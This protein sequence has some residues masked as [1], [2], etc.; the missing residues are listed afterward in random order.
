MSKTMEEICQ[1]MM[2]AAGQQAPAAASVQRAASSH[3]LATGAAV[4]AAAGLL[5]GRGLL[6]AVFANPLVMLTTGVAAG[7]LVHKYQREIIATAIR[8]TDM[9]KDFALEQKE[10]LSDL[11][12]EAKETEES[13]TVGEIQEE[14]PREEG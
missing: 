5:A 12:E 1:E 13:R 7:Y 10:K 11:I 4:T 9:A 6:R 2:S 8:T 3:P 14:P